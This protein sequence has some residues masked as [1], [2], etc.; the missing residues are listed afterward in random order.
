MSLALETNKIAKLSTVLFSQMDE[1][2]FFSELSRYLSEH[3]PSDKVQIHITFNDGSTQLIAENGKAVESLVLAKGLGLSGYVSRMKRAYYS[4]NVKRDPLA[5]H[6][7][8][9][10]EIEAECAMPIISEGSVI[11]TI[12]LQSHQSNRQYGENEVTFIQEILNQVQAPLRNMKLLMVA[13]QLN[14]ELQQRLEKQQIEGVSFKSEI[15]Q[16]VQNKDERIN[17]VGISKSF[18]DMVQISKK[19]A[20]QDFPILIEGSHGTGKKLLARKV[21]FWSARKERACVMIHCQSMTESA[22]DLELFGKKNKKGALAEANNG[23]II[24]DGISS[25]SLNLQSKLLRMMLTGEAISADLEEVTKLN[26]RIIAISKED[27]S[28]KVK[29]GEFKEELYYR[30]NT[31]SIKSSDLKDRKEDIKVLAENFINNNRKQDDAKILTHGALQK[32]NE[33]H[34]PGNIQELKNLMERSASIVDGRYIDETHLPEL[35][36]QEV[37]VTRVEA[38]KFVE[39]TLFDLE[40]AHIIDTL[41]HLSGNKTRAAKSLGITVKT[42][43]NKLHSYGLIEAK[44]E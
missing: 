30:L 19:L 33:Y 14:K 26:V 32:L 8:R 23:S 24:L 42:L 29:N 13:Q 10:V 4:N 25:L 6:G 34:W 3:M 7:T 35:K 44:A 39:S 9:S 18:T 11:G 22:L 5:T 38:P 21:H 28:L 27:L 1:K 31:M 40:K 36:A 20:A 2:F 37:V 43:Y 17:L 16:G 15:N 41:D 12:H